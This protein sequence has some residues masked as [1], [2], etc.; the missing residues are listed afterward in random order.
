MDWW[1][2]WPA[3]LLGW[4]SAISGIV[5][6]GVG[7]AKSS[8]RLAAAGAASSIGFCVYVATHSWPLGTVLMLANISAVIAVQRGHRLVASLLI[9]PFTTIASYL[10]YGVMQTT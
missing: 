6:F 5:L 10:A 1:H 4:P 2:W 3:V 7:A 8:F 9:L